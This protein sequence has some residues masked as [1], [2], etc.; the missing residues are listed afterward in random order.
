[1]YNTNSRKFKDYNRGETREENSRK[2]HRVTPNIY[3]ISLFSI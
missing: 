2:S 1:M 3:N